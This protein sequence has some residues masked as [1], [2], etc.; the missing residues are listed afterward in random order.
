MSIKQVEN[1]SQKGDGEINEDQILIKEN[2]FAVFDGATSLNKYVDKNGR[3]GGFIASL[4]AKQEF[5]KNEGS[6]IQLANRANLKIAEAMKRKNID[7]SS[8]INRW[9]AGFA[10][11]RINNNKMEWVQIADCLILIIKK[12]LSYNLLV[13]DYDHDVKVI[14]K[15]RDL[16]KLSRKEKRKI[17]WPDI[18]SLRKEQNV[19][20]GVLNGEQKFTKFI[21]HGIINL[22]KAA[23]IL[24][25]TDGF[26]IPKSD[27]KAEDNFNQFVDYYLSGGLKYLLEKVREIEDKDPECQKFPRHKTHD[28]ASA[29][30]IIL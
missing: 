5:Q 3:T 22:E 28:D 15:W 7:T 9:S 4:I 2:F 17:L 11:I 18:L 25:F 10:A 14:Q 6:L 23:H 30:S 27:P 24:I 13:N 29:I 19:N 8:K 1:I 12:D 20:F 21:K 16:G 26:L